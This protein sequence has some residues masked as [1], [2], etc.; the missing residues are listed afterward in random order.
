MDQEVYEQLLRDAYAAI[1]CK[2][3]DVKIIIKPH[4]REKIEFIERLCEK[5]CFNNIETSV[6]HAAVLAANSYA[7]IAFFTSAVFDSFSFRVPTFEYFVEPKRFR[8]VEPEGSL[9]KRAGVRSG[10]Q[11]RDLEEFMDDVKSRTYEE[12]KI[13]TR[14]RIESEGRAVRSL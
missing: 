12:P 8:D 14:W 7:A 5:N 11:I 10:S 3:G 4:P 2:F 6:E 9:Y 1:R 13:V